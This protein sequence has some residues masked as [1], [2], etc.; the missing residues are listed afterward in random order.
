[1]RGWVSQCSLLRVFT[2]DISLI[3]IYHVTY[4]S[5]LHSTYLVVGNASLIQ[6][7]RKLIAAFFQAIKYI[8]IYFVHFLSFFRLLSK[9]RIRQQPRFRVDSKRYLN[10]R[11]ELVGL[12]VPTPG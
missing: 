5:T 10:I 1:M 3:I 7:N 11:I 4:L 9:Q 2:T 8:M 12:R 6:A